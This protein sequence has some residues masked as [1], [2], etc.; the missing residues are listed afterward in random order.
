MERNPRISTL[1]TELRTLVAALN[2]R[3]RSQRPAGELGEAAMAVLL[4]LQKVG[5]QTLTDL[6]SNAGVS[7]GSMSQTL[8][9]LEELDYV[10]REPDPRDRRRTLLAATPVGLEV[11]ADVRARLEAW[12]D[13]QITQLEEDDL[14]RLESSLPALR[15]LADLPGHRPRSRTPDGMGHPHRR[16]LTPRPHPRDAHA[17]Q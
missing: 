2:R 8:R 14:Q 12:F 4:R 6:S 7:L 13:E 10:A 11:A 16:H 3:Y 1:G 5:P 9:R 17:D 15:K